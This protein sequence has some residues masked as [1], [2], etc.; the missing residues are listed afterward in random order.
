MI[1][2]DKPEEWCNCKE[3]YIRTLSFCIDHFFYNG[4]LNLEMCIFLILMVNMGG[5]LD[6]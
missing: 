5:I 4:E 6:V 1:L 2:F 3:L